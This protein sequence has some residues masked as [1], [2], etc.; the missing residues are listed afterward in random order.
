MHGEI[1]DVAANTTQNS[2][3]IAS[4]SNTLHYDYITIS[5]I[6]DQLTATYIQQYEKLNFSVSILN[7]SGA[8]QINVS[9]ILD[10]IDEASTESYVLPDDTPL[11]TLP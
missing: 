6:N 1:D 9:N 3:N 8:A 10:L 7:M 5:D 2:S 4:L 11:T